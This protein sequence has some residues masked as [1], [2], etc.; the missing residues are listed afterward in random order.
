MYG[1]THGNKA[2]SA[3]PHMSCGRKTP[4]LNSSQC[5]QCGSTFNCWLCQSKYHCNRCGLA[6]CK[7][8]C[9]RTARLP[10][11]GYPNDDKQLRVCSKCHQCAVA[12]LDLLETH[13][14]VLLQGARY[15]KHGTILVSNV[16]LQLHP[17]C[18]RLEYWKPCHLTRTQV[19]E[20]KGLDVGSLR[21]VW[22][23]QGLRLRVTGVDQGAEKTMHLEALEGRSKKEWFSALRS[24][25]N[26]KAI[27]STSEFF[28]VVAASVG[29]GGGRNNNSSGNRQSHPP[30]SQQQQEKQPAPPGPPPSAHDSAKS[31]WQERREAR[32]ARMD[33]IAKKY[34]K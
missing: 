6:F 16:R 10:F 11:W 17:S 14:P 28:R 9:E 13:L 34:A 5:H 21:G 8:C 22:D 26:L 20:V 4:T 32:A 29:S 31:K 2:W 19:G 3:E 24:L 33:K 15:K 1:S 12:E 23:A 18:R 27:V 30:H 25:L 7:R